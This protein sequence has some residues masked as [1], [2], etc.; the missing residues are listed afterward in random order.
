MPADQ[1]PSMCRDVRVCV[2]VCVCVWVWV[3]I[4]CERQCERKRVCMCVNVCKCV[5]RGHSSVRRVFCVSI[6]P[7][8]LSASVCVFVLT[9]ADTRTLP[10]AK[11]SN[12]ANT[13]LHIHTD[14]IRNPFA[15]TELPSRQ[16]AR[17]HVNMRGSNDNHHAYDADD[18]EDFSDMRIDSARLIQHRI[19]LPRDGG[20]CHVKECV[21]VCVWCVCVCVRVCG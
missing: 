19:G 4:T 2:C 9:W 7:F 15:S 14:K 16:S 13:A 12:S 3:R 18:D 10:T 17:G 5:S 21:C 8:C 1:S 11:Q 6:C 20:R